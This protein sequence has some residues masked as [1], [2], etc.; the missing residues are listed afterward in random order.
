MAGSHNQP[1][2]DFLTGA[3]TSSAPFNQSRREPSG[4]RS[5]TISKPVDLSTEEW[6]AQI[7]KLRYEVDSLRQEREA[8]ALRHEDELRK[9]QSTAEASHTRA[10]VSRIYRSTI[11]IRLTD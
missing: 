9:V 11:C 1:Q 7:H 5:S 4:A 10:K 2:Y 8:T 6:R 3:E